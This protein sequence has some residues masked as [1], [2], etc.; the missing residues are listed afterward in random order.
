MAQPDRKEQERSDRRLCFINKNG[1]NLSTKDHLTMVK[2]HIHHEIVR[3]KRQGAKATAKKL[4]YSSTVWRIN[5]SVSRGPPPATT[6]SNLSE[7]YRLEAAES[8]AGRHCG[9]RGGC[10]YVEYPNVFNGTWRAFER[11]SRKTRPASTV[12]TSRFANPY[13]AD[14]ICRVM[15]RRRTSTR[16]G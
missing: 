13:H 8:G 10:A 5:A 9:R 11:H 3:P 14:F 12:G 16:H 6:L 4:P 2:K 15:S 7:S 1:K